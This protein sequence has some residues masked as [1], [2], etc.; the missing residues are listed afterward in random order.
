MHPLAGCRAKLD[1]ADRH[2]E[3]FKVAVRGYLDTSPYDI[4]AE[5]DPARWEQPEGL[6]RQ[7][8]RFIDIE[9][10]QSIGGWHGSETRPV[11]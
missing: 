11:T 3:E 2:V 10:L 1:M 6:H 8:I 5:D 7:G 4:R 9:F